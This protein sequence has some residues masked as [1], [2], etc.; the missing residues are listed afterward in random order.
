L[1]HG[2]G[3]VSLGFLMDAVADRHRTHAIVPEEIFASDLM[4][5]KDVCR[6]TD[7]YWDFGV[8]QQ[9]KWNDIQNT[10]KDVQLLSN[11]LLVHYKTLVWAAGKPP[12]QA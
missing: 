6:W 3:V 2:A 1:L 7:G 10:H 4:H 12:V 9:R 5:L 8:G 11:H